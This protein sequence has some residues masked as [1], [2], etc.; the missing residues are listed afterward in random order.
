MAFRSGLYVVWKGKEYPAT[1]ISS[2]EFILY[3][4]DPSDSALGLCHTGPA[5]WSA[6]VRS[7][8]VD[9]AFTVRQRGRFMGQVVSVL[10]RENGDVCLWSADKA[11]R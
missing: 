5:E 1:R 3:S 11:A 8:D 10:P 7:T 9:A 2:D 4:S 6:R